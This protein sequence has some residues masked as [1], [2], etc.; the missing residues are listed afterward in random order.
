MIGRPKVKN[1]KENLSL[2]IDKELIVIVDKHLK[3]KNINKSEYV[4]QLLIKEMIK[5]Q[6]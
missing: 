3:E 6:L 4:E 2:T 5:R 1:K